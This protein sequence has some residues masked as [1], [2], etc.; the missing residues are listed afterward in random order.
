[1]QNFQDK[2]EQKN[3]QN[4]YNKS[5]SRVKANLKSRTAR[6]D[7]TIQVNVMLH[8]YCIIR[9]Y[10]HYQ[11]YSAIW[12]NAIDPFYN[13][14]MTICE[15]ANDIPILRYNYGN[16]ILFSVETQKYFNRSYDLPLNW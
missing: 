2:M 13:L 5:M 10:H 16:Q 8:K 9:H 11:W 3:C 12:Y 15:S 6:W 14:F 7:K 1:M 4:K